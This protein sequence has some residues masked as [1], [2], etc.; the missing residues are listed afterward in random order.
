MRVVADHVRGEAIAE[1][2]TRAL[3]PRVEVVGVPAV[4][5]VHGAGE[6]LTRCPQQ[7]VVVRSHQAVAEA[8]HVE[9]A[10][11]A[12]EQR[13]ED[14]AIVVVREERAVEH[15]AARDVV[16]AV[17]QVVAGPPRHGARS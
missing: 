3:V 1:D 10:Q 5:P 15:G 8:V 9:L 11:H 2:V 4:Q 12:V 13:Q 17:G 6:I 16:D 7:Q 14:A